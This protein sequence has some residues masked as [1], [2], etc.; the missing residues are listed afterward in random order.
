MKKTKF[1]PMLLITLILAGCSPVN[2]IQ[3]TS[4]PTSYTKEDFDYLS[5]DRDTRETLGICLNISPDKNNYFILDPISNFRNIYLVENNSPESVIYDYIDSN[6]E[7]AIRDMDEIQVFWSGL[8][9]RIYLYRPFRKTS[10][11][12]YYTLSTHSW[13]SID[14]SFMSGYRIIK[15]IN[16]SNNFLASKDGHFYSINISDKQIL[17]LNIPDNSFIWDHS[18]KQVLFTNVETRENSE[19]CRVGIYDLDKD[20]FKYINTKNP[21]S[22]DSLAYFV[23]NSLNEIS[24]LTEII[25]NSGRLS[26]YLEIYDLSSESSRTIYIGDGPQSFIGWDAYGKA[27]YGVD[28]IMKK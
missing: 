16:H 3:N 28:Y 8:S 2:D 25:D 20:T 17:Q 24:Y 23:P 9:D 5:I 26:S 6:G 1:I 15:A 27:F 10:E 12:P 22:R 13:K 11:L 18:M 21:V 14:I 7:N 4:T 19:S